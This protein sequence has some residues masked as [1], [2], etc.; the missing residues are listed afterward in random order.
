MPLRTLEL[1]NCITD[2]FSKRCGCS[3]K[4]IT[5][6]TGVLPS[7]SKSRIKARIF[8]QR[9]KMLNAYIARTGEFL[10]SQQTVF[11]CSIKLFNAAAHCP[12]RSE[13]RKSPRNLVA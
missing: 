4:R 13:I 3:K 5:L 11:I 6:Q 1:C 12:L 2:H 10:K 8:E 9:A 7:P